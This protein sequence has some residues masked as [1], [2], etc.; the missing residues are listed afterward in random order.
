MDIL[1]KNGRGLVFENGKFQMTENMADSLAQRLSIRLKTVLNTWYLNRFYGIDYFNRVFEKT[2]SKLSI[3]TMFTVEINK[4]PL[5]DQI[6]S[7]KSVIERNEYKL[8]F[9]VRLR[10]GET[11]EKITILVNEQGKAIV[12]ENGFAIRVK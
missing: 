4:E 3:D 8:D 10:S 5:V 1:M 2:I 6:I 11:T 9:K 12:T 7:F